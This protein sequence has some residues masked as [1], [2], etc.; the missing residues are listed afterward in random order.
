LDR[1]L[2]DATVGVDPQVAPCD[3]YDRKGRISVNTDAAIHTPR[4]AQF[5]RFKRWFPRA[6]AID[7]ALRTGAPN[8]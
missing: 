8:Q 4:S 5:A 7:M 6:I 1:V 2:P 3:A